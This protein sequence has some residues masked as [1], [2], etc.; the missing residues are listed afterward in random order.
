MRLV[1]VHGF[2][3]SPASW[4]AVRRHIPDHVRA[5]PIEVVT[6]EVPDGL[7][8]ASTARAVLEM[9]GRAT[10]GGYSLGGRLCLR[11]ALDFPDLVRAVVLVSASPGIANDEERAERAR[12]DDELASRVGSIGVHAFLRQWLAQP[13]FSTL[14]AG[15]DEV[16]G[17]ASETSVERLEHQL[18]VLGQGAQPPMWEALPSLGMPVTVVTGR[19]DHKYESI[20]DD[21]VAALPGSVRVH[22]DGGH[23]LPLEHPEAVARAMTAAMERVLAHGSAP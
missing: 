15:E 17:R 11:G 14:E 16:A 20:G 19:K 10:Y 3:Q 12:L 23:A 18:R 7:D 9:G 2:T 4:D 8:F 22:V 13:L 1:L 5:E 21:M 6:P